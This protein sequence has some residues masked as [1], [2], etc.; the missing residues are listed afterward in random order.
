MSSAYLISCLQVATNNG[1]TIALPSIGKE[2]DFDESKLQWLV[3]AYSLSSV[4]PRYVVEKMGDP[5]T[6]FSG[7]LATRA[8]PTGRFVW[9]EEIVH[10]GLLL[11]VRTQLGVFF[12]QWSGKLSCLSLAGSNAFHQTP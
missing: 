9:Q 8:G 1:V 11:A 7:M 6:L 4:C 12:C 3:S 2:L 10:D 5:L